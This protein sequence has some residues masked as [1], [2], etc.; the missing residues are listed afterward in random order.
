LEKSEAAVI[1][2]EM[3]GIRVGKDKTFDYGKRLH[4]F[5]SLFISKTKLL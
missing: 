3:H 4:F 5:S 1:I 2:Q